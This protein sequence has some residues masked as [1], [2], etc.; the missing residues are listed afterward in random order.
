MVQEA[1]KQAVPDAMPDAM[2]DGIA[3][4]DTASA[5]TSASAPDMKALEEQF[6]AAG[7]DIKALEEHVKAI[8]LAAME[9]NFKAA[10]RTAENNQTL[11]LA[12][13]DSN[14]ASCRAEIAAQIA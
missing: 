1:V 10:R 12:E 3:K 2:P 8:S 9:D 11:L 5:S 4:P 13:M 7:S 14:I 6:K